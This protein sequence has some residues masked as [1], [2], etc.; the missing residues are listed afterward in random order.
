MGR[1]KSVFGNRTLL[2][3]QSR[4]GIYFELISA[5]SQHQITIQAMNNK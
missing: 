3:Y 1:S 5:L 2:Y 4:G